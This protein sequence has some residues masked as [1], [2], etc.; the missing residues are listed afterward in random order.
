MPEP[1]STFVV[2][3]PPLAPGTHTVKRVWEILDEMNLRT[4]VVFC[5]QGTMVLNGLGF[6]TKLQ[7][8]TFKLKL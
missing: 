1:E 8:I 2:F 5:Y 4:E 6:P 3:D 7:A